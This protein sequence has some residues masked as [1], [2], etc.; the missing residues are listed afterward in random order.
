M[1]QKLYAC[2]KPEEI[3]KYFIGSLTINAFEGDKVK[4]QVGIKIN[5]VGN[6]VMV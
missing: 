2:L 1:P 4:K 6:Y 3:A 5:P